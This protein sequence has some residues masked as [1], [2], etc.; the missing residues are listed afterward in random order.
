MTQQW[1]SAAR[2]LF[3]VGLISLQLAAESAKSTAADWSGWLWGPLVGTGMIV[4][5][6]FI[7][8]VL[9]KDRPRFS[10][11][12]LVMA[13]VVVSL[14]VWGAWAAAAS[15]LTNRVVLFSISVCLI[16]LS[17]GV[18]VCIFWRGLEKALRAVLPSLEG[19]TSVL[20]A[21]SFFVTI[22]RVFAAVKRSYPGTWWPDLILVLGF[23]ISLIVVAL[24][25]LYDMWLHRKEQVL[26]E[27]QSRA[28]TEAAAE[29][30]TCCSWGLFTYFKG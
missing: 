11:L 21:L 18:C 23:T 8:F 13:G 29:T 20:L 7:L 17:L 24:S 3:V 22:V 19:V 15:G 27:E 14:V 1:S 26:P 28:G 4:L 25:P 6:A 12:R 16:G 30:H 10:L 2:A 5:L 9:H